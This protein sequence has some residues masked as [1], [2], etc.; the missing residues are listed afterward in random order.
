[1]VP[2]RYRDA[3]KAGAVMVQW[4]TPSLALFPPDELE[5]EM[6][7]W[8]ASAKTT[9]DRLELEEYFNSQCSLVELDRQGR[10][11]LTT[12]MKAHADIEASVQVVGAGNH[13]RFWNPG[14]WTAQRNA[15]R[16]R[17]TDILGRS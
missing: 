3:F 9:Q 8:G 4:T 1:M 7:K 6:A 10:V 16:A 13:L 5:A 12:E 17:V 15:L 2:A 11:L 14:R